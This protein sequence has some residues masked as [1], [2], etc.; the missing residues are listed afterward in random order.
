ML[1]PK[2]SILL[3]GAG[4]NNHKYPPAP[5]V[6][7]K[8]SAGRRRDEV[9]LDAGGNVI[10]IT[11]GATG[12]GYALAERF[13]EEGSE[14]IVCGRRKNKLQAAKEQLPA[15]HVRQ[16]D[17]AIESERK[18]LLKWATTSFPDLNILV[19]NAGIQRK[20]DFTSLKIAKPLGAKDDEVTINLASQI[21]LCALLTPKLMKRN[22]AAI[23]NISSG[24]AFAPIAT[25]PIYCA[26]K[27]AIHSFTTSLRHQLRNT[28]IRV[29]E[30]VP[31][32]TDTE[33]DASFAGEEEQAYRGISPQE[34]ARAIIEGMKADKEEIIIGQ[35]QGLYQ[36]ALQ[37]PKAIFAKLNS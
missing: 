29:F 26:T 22:R 7:L 14:V 35:A 11:G 21:R 1:E 16:C 18:S 20:V 23:L 3:G 27:A 8:R 24:L 32:T 19:N 2:D 4:K 5:K 28:S 13:V 6:L 17:V 12:I 34:V 33:L 9:E 15:I 25:M 31:P 36:A 30:A 37:D 10:L